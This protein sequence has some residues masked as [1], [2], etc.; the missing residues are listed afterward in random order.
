VNEEKKVGAGE[1]TAQALPSDA[2]TT[3]EQSR[4]GSIVPEV[5]KPDENRPGLIGIPLIDAFDE[6]R[7]GDRT[8]LAVTRHLSRE[9]ER[10]DALLEKRDVELSRIR[11]ELSAERV[12]NAQ[13]VGESRT[14]LS[15]FGS[16]AVALGIAICPTLPLLG[17][18]VGILGIVSITI[19]LWPRRGN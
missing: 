9:V 18:V 2:G 1:E 15:V 14:A 5:V 10:R 12:R 13:I 7:R 6:S 4:G 3:E 8:A 19:G 17:G 11:D 16:I